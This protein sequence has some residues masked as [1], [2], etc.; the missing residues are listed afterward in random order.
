MENINVLVELIN[1]LGFPMVMVGY[2]IWDKSK[3]T[4]KLVQAIDNNN[5]I[6]SKLLAKLNASSIED[7]V[8]RHEE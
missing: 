3:L 2:F 7:E 8:Y 5:L 1:N 6:L 4:N